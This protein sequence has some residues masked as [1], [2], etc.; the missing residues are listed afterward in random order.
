[1]HSTFKFYKN[2]GTRTGYPGYPGIRVKPGTLGISGNRGTRGR[3]RVSKTE[4]PGS[5]SRFP[6]FTQYPG[7]RS[8]FTPLL[9]CGQFGHLIKN[10]FSYPEFLETKSQRRKYVPYRGAVDSAHFSSHEK[11]SYPNFCIYRKTLGKL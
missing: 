6:G 11:R 4:N 5:R 10:F 9:A 7:T 1:M 3:G 2:C 8:G